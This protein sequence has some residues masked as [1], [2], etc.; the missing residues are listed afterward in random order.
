[1]TIKELKLATSSLLSQ[2][3]LFF[4]NFG[5]PHDEVVQSVTTRDHGKNRHLLVDDHL[6]QHRF[7]AFEELLHAL[8][9]LFLSA[10][11]NALDAHG[12]SQLH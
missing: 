12:F 1:M 2:L 8:F 7:L 4:F 10:N 5:I 6:Q 9:H 11:A 3:V